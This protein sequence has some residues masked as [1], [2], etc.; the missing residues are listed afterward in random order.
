MSGIRWTTGIGIAVGG[1]SGALLAFLNTPRAPAVTADRSALAAASSEGTAPLAAP[2][3][4]S[5]AAPEASTA[6]TAEEPVLAVSVAESVSAQGAP[7]APAAPKGASPAAFGVAPPLELPTTREGLLKAQLYC[8]KRQ[9]FDECS[10]AAAALE[11]GSAGP[12]DPAQARRFRRIALTHLVAQCEA[13]SAHACF[14]M[15]SKYREGTEL[16]ASPARAEALE[17]RALELCRLG[18]AAPECPPAP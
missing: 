3:V 1:L 17:K 11:A 15:A 12:A 6:P 10:R 14:V 16:A 18:R 7:A 5:A 4:E 13:G 8:D 9:D 2:P